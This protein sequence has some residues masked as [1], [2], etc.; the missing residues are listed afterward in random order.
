MT[1]MHRQ[2]PNMQNI[3][4]EGTEEQY[5]LQL[6]TDT[7]DGKVVSSFY[8][9]HTK[10]RGDYYCH[11]APA[12][13][14]CFMYFVKGKGTL[15]H[16]DEEFYPTGGDLFLL[17]EGVD[18]E[19]A[20][21]PKSPW[22]LYWFN[23]DDDFGSALLRFFGLDK[24]IILSYEKAEERMKSLLT[25]L[26]FAKRTNAD[27]RD[28]IIDKLM[29][30]LKEASRAKNAVGDS[31]QSRDARAM[32]KYI[33]DH[34][35]ENIRSTDVSAAVF[36]SHSGA[37]MLFRRVYGLTIKEYIL[38]VKLETGA[39][40][41]SETDMPIWKIAAELAFYDSRHFSRV[42]AARY[43]TPPLKLRKESRKNQKTTII[44][45]RKS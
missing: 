19:Y 5:G 35:G 40:L 42:F 21:D 33:D 23:L 17:H 8:A 12:S 30:L 14:N 41:L 3:V 7:Q 45:R 6:H 31:K 28:E 15:S 25:T 13:H 37:S 20:T 4:A 27:L 44:K 32:R 16:G 38:K 10:C 26:A 24:A 43:G 2:M 9:G 36:R 1:L 18:W 29:L 34:V 22:E 11:F 39:R